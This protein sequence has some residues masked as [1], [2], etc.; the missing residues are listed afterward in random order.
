MSNSVNLDISEWESFNKRVLELAEETMPRETK[1]FMRREGG[2]LA[3]TTRK[4]A[5]S[6]VKKKT[7]NYFKSIKSSKAWRNSQGGY[8]VYALAS[9][10]TGPHA[11]LLEYGHR[12]VIGKR[13]TG[14]K[15]RDFR[16]FE[17]AAGDFDKKFAGDT[18]EFIDNL[19]DSNFTSGKARR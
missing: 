3:T 10:K 17:K 9:H 19:L 6:T 12:I 15:T 4:L 2:R 13:D 11:H 16:I 18:E 5:R 1:K 8:G 7:G 14:K